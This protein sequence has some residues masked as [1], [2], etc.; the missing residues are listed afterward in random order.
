L[1]EKKPSRKAG[2]ENET[3]RTRSRMKGSHNRIQNKNFKG[4][5][6][7]REGGRGGGEMR[8]AFSVDVR[9]GL[10]AHRGKTFSCALQPENR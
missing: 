3:G 9:R 7:V 10:N 2:R 5:E 6:K 1:P 4:K 8:I